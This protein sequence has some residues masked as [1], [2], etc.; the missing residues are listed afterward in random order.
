M[1]ACIHREKVHACVHTPLNV[2]VCMHTPWKSPCMH[3]YTFKR[4]CTHAYTVEKSTHARIHLET[5]MHACIH[6][7]KVHACMHTL[8]IVH[9]CTH[10]PWKSPR[11]HAYKETFV[12]RNFKTPKRAV[13]KGKHFDLKNCSDS[14]VSTSRYGENNND[15]MLPVVSLE[16]AHTVEKSTHACIHHGK[17][18]ACTHTP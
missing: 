16:H 17:V 3:A 11:M 15:V 4:P 12:K 6:R 7:G 14:A 10:T 2:H 9:A 1:H 5:S 13:Q 18:H 8:L